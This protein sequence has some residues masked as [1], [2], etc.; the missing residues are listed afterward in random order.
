MISDKHKCIFVHL[1]RTGGNSIELSLGGIELLDEHYRPTTSWNNAL[2]RG[3]SP[4]KIDRRGHKIHETA[5]GIRSLFPEK[6]NK[7]RKFSIIRNPWDQ[8]VS[9]YSRRLEQGKVTCDFERWLQTF[10]SRKG[11][12]PRASIFDDDGNI[13][14]D[15]VGRFEDLGNEYS[16][17]CA[18]L[19]LKA[20]PLA[21]LNASTRDD[22]AKYYNRASRALVDDIFREDIRYFGFRF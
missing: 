20:D 21:Q 4:Y 12:V 8:M 11:T 22:Y 13:L 15:E 3:S 5:T 14:V 16:R 7:Y 19:D 1:R 9:I 18:S 17:I 2:H 10:K 6:F